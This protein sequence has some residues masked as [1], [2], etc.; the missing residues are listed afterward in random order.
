MLEPLGYARDAVAI[1][2]NPCDIESAWVL[3]VVDYAVPSRRRLVNI[4][5]DRLWWS[6]GW[7]YQIPLLA[8]SDVLNLPL[9]LEPEPRNQVCV[10]SY[11]TCVDATQDLYE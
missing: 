8:P 5:Y 3:K 11:V 10:I 2:D 4:L 9:E 6:V 1:K 7:L